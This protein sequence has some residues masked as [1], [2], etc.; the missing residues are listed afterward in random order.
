MKPNHGSFAALVWVVAGVW[1]FHAEPEAQVLSWQSVAYFFAG[2]FVAAFVMGNLSF[3][4]VRGL[5]E[6]LVR[7]KIVTKPTRRAA[8]GL[9]VVGDL[10]FAGQALLIYFVARWTIR[11]IF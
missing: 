4:A 2:M 11:E 6:A 8:I 5:T 1:L 9:S 10:M 7:T 3:F